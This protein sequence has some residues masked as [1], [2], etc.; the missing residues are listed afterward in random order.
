MAGVYPHANVNKTMQKITQ[1]LELMCLTTKCIMK[2]HPQ[3]TKLRLYG[4][5]K[6]NG[7]RVFLKAGPLVEEYLQSLEGVIDVAL[8]D[9]KR[10][11]A[12]RFDLHFPDSPDL[13]SE[14][15][16]SAAITRFIESFKAQIRHDRKLAK[17]A[18]RTAANTVVRY[19]CACERYNAAYPHWH[20]AFLLNWDAFSK[21]GLYKLGHDNMYNRVIKAWASALQMK[22][23]EV[24]G[25]VHF[26]RNAEYR[27]HRDDEASIDEFFHRASYLCKAASKQYGSGQ[28]GFRSSR[29]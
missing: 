26:P 1:I 25:L 21:I 3:N 11:F 19:V 2:R 6:Y 29:R 22:V 17:R 20:V 13:D 7:K 16:T 14:I 27:L 23:E 9:Y 5:P 18:R 10:V 24:I 12:F 28:H 4:Q 15:F 8:R